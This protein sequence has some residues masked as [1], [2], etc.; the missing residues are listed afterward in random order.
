MPGKI[1]NLTV[2]GQK[3]LVFHRFYDSRCGNGRYFR[4]SIEIGRL[5]YFLIRIAS[6]NYLILVA[7]SNFS[8]NIET[9][10]H[11]LE[12]SFSAILASLNFPI[13]R[14]R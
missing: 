3:L 13:F 12:H 8:L 2:D 14:R 10:E 1:R 11:T 6:K 7:I 5:S 4:E 9:I